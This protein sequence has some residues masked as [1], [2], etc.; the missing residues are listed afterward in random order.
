MVTGRSDD[1]TETKCDV[2]SI[3]F[4]LKTFNLTGPVLGPER[5]KLWRC[6]QHETPKKLFLFLAK[7]KTINNNIHF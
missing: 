5:M 4:D 7:I 2:V 6:L 3:K 1:V